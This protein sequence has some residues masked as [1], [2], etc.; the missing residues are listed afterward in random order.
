MKTSW[1]YS[2]NVHLKQEVKKFHIGQP[3]SM[4]TILRNLGDVLNL[5]VRCIIV[6]MKMLWFHILSSSESESESEDELELTRFLTENYERQNLVSSRHSNSLVTWFVFYFIYQFII[7]K[8]CFIKSNNM[9]YIL[10]SFLTDIL[11]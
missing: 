5:Q 1:Y 4:F 8:S 6:N 3:L 9:S 7:E 11:L 10:H 2:I